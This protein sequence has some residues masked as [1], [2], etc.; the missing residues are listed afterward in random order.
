MFIR[1]MMRVFI[2]CEYTVQKIHLKSTIHFV[3]SKKKKKT[4]FTSTESETRKDKKRQEDGKRKQAQRKG[5]VRQN[6]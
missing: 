2:L 5:K 1:L 4:E 3:M 6:E